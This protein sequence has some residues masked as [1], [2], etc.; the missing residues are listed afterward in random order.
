MKPVLATILG[1]AATAAACLAVFALASPSGP[2]TS[3]V[4]PVATSTVSMKATPSIATLY[5]RTEDA[6][7]YVQTQKGSGSGFLVSSDGAVVTND[8]VVDGASR[9]TVRF[10]EHGKAVTARVVGTDPSTDVAVLDVPASAI[11]T[12]TPL[13]LG[14][15]SNLQVGQSALAIGSPFGLSGTL[16]SGVVSALGRDIESPNGS[17]ISGAVQTDAAINPGNSGGPLLNADGAVIGINS[18][19]ATESGSN[20][21]VG[22]AVPINTVRQVVNRFDAGA[23]QA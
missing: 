5:A 6:V 16:T 22:F 2:S 12:I 7:A 18:Q 9:V 23:L 21:G 20:S 19:I 14:S 17:T 3:T 10:G 1:A 8:H 4:E 15:S 13:T 11:K